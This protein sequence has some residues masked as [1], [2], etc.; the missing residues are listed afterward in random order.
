MTKEILVDISTLMEIEFGKNGQSLVLMFYGL[1]GE[2][3]KLECLNLLLVRYQTGLGPLPLMVCQV[4]QET[5][6]VYLA[7][8]RLTR[9]GFKDLSEPEGPQ[10]QHVDHLLFISLDA[11]EL[12]MVIVCTEVRLELGG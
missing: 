10:K 2:K 6:P 9:L 8:E 3:I 5:V 12:D 1:D 7:G 4:A 11:A